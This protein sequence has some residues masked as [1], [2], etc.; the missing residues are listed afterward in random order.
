MVIPSS[1][2]LLPAARG[3]A[4]VPFMRQFS[5]WWQSAAQPA[6]HLNLSSKRHMQSSQ[7]V[8]TCALVQ[9][10]QQSMAATHHLTCIFHPARQ[11]FDSSERCH[12]PNQ[13]R[14][15]LQQ[16]QLP[17]SSQITCHASRQKRHAACFTQT[18]DWHVSVPMAWEFASCC[19]LDTAEMS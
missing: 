1:E 10:V 2:Q 8:D 15:H 16:T 11:D 12:R 5:S 7:V 4:H 19:L 13:P 18:V 6:K 14:N 9:A 17:L 3:L